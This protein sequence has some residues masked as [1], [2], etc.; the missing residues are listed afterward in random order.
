MW[1]S[2][3]EESD[4]DSQRTSQRL[5]HV[6]GAILAT[7]TLN[8]LEVVNEQQADAPTTLSTITSTEDERAL[9]E[10]VAPE[11]ITTEDETSPTE[12]T[13]IKQTGE[14]GKKQKSSGVQHGK[15]TKPPK[16]TDGLTK[17][18][19]EARKIAEVNVSRPE[20]PPKLDKEQQSKAK[21][22]ET[23]ELKTSA[24][25]GKQKGAT[26]KTTVKT[27][28]FPENPSKADNV[29]HLE[30]TKYTANVMKSEDEK[31]EQ[32]QPDAKKQAEEDKK[33]QADAAAKT[34]TDQQAKDKVAA[35][36]KKAEDE[37][38]KLFEADAKKQ[39]E[40]DK[41]Q[42]A[43]GEAKAKADEEAKKKAAGDSKKAEDVKAKQAQ[44]DANKQTEEDKQKQAEEKPISKQALNEPTM[45]QSRTGTQTSGMSL[46]QPPSTD[47][48]LAVTASDPVQESAPLSEHRS[49][50]LA[51]QGEHRSSSTEP[52]R[53]DKPRATPDTDFRSQHNQQTTGI[54]R[55]PR[56]M[57]MRQ[58]LP[59][60]RR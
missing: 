21:S 52:R 53:R 51:T 32:A 44:A 58:G 38:R 16:P 12:S 37:K 50:S 5:P 26:P 35:D 43:A 20:T 29:M 42:T 49:D 30:G 24:D 9:P 18:D 11:S 3:E 14:R 23:T 54:G 57:F 7:S 33:M 34:R 48:Q 28:A 22:S 13:A 41:K 36:A 2:F 15:T 8:E 19:K 25:H 39:A 56:C 46:L 45:Q 27:E 55:V 47:Q 40:Q 17:K 60:Q 6:P 4:E 31:A 1:K 10:G 59:N